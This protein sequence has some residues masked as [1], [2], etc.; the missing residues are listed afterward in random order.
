MGA[1]DR[2]RS[3]SL[4]LT[5]KHTISLSLLVDQPRDIGDTGGE[6]RQT[7]GI[8]VRLKENKPEPRKEEAG[9]RRAKGR[10][11]KRCEERG[12]RDRERSLEG[13]RSEICAKREA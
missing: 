9:G 11:S 4:A 8:H 12:P 5:S 1:G 13:A 2:S 3:S 10:G 7:G 6:N